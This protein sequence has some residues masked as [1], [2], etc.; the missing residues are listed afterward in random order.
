MDFTDDPIYFLLLNHLIF[1]NFSTSPHQ[2]SVW[3]KI[4]SYHFPM[5]KLK[6]KMTE[7]MGLKQIVHYEKLRNGE[8]SEK[9][10][11]NNINHFISS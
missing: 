8:V 10:K 1:T 2:K 4:M 3:L 5:T 7:K 11:E 6:K 9:S